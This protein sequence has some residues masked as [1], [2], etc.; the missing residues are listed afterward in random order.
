MAEA[1][2]NSAKNEASL[3]DNIYL[4]NE[5]PVTLEELQGINDLSEIDDSS[6]IYNVN[7]GEDQPDDIAS[8]RRQKVKESRN[9]EENEIAVL[10][11]ICNR[12]YKTTVS[13]TSHLRKTHNFYKPDRNKMPCL[14]SGCSFRTNRIVRLITHLIRSHKLKFQCEKVTFQQKDG[15]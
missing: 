14:E 7:L 4:K 2:K 12:M 15:K 5:I 6:S 3:K 11:P 13:L 10:C 8:S 9:S 1:L